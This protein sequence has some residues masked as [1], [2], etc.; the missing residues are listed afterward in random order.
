MISYMQKEHT[1]LR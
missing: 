1:R